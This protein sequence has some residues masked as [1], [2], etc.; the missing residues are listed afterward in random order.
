MRHSNISIRP[1]G[2]RYSFTQY[3]AGGL[4]QWVDHGYQTE[5]AYKKGW[6]KARKQAEEAIAAVG[7]G[8]RHVL[9]AS[10]A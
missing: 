6:T 2:D 1:G 7:S 10:P 4:F 8:C 5:E 9:H 3:T